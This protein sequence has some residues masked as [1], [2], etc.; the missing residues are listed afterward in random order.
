[1]ARSPRT[2]RTQPPQRPKADPPAARPARDP[3]KRTWL[4]GPPPRTDGYA[5]DRLGLP[6][7]GRGSVGS[8]GA[9]L[10]ALLID[11]VVAGI[12]AAVIVRP[13]TLPQEHVYG[14]VSDGV[15]VVVS[16]LALMFGG[17]TTGML[18]TNLQVVRLDGRTMGWK[19]LPRQV[20]CALII[21]AVITDRDRR[22]LHDKLLGT[23]VVRVR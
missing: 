5:G 12:V 2:V 20:L 17:R 16:A 3:E 8:S 4:D 6:Q 22:G 1:M 18:A 11:F 7:T 19:A 9:K 21:P 13:H 14:Y 23:I 15:F 10:G